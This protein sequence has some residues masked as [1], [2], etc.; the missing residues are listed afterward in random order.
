MKISYPFYAVTFLLAAAT[1]IQAQSQLRFDTDFPGGNIIVE[2]VSNDTVY[3]KPDLRDTEGYW[4]YWYFSLKGAEG[5]SLVFKFANNAAMAAFGPAV[6]LDAGKNWKWLYDKPAGRNSFSYT[7]PTDARE[8]RFSMGMAYTQSNFDEFIAKHRKNPFLTTG[9]LC[10]SER[11]RQVEKISIRSPRKKAPKHRVLI[12]A[13]HHACEMMASYELEGIIDAVLSDD[14][15]MKWLRENVEFLIVPF[16]DKDGVEDGDQGKYR[17][18]RDH[19]RDYSDASLYASTGTLR[20]T[21]PDWAEG[22]LV[23]GL[24]LHCPY[25]NGKDHENTHLVGSPDPEFAANQK[26]FASMIERNVKG[27]LSFVADINFLA[28]GTSWNKASNTTQGKSFNQWVRGVEGV[29]LPVTIEF[30]Y[31]INRGEMITAEN[32]RAFGRDIAAAI[33]E[34]LK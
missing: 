2:R 12:T 30:P 33:R 27:E 4:F 13:R 5:R 22:K 16:M 19:N 26:K 15:D 6:S 23:I 34:Y 7:F 31:A 28:F 1:G 10:Q 8:V 24:D 9:V 21:V 3:L 14:K 20:K 11:G 29:T 18:P 17:K 32:A 25:I